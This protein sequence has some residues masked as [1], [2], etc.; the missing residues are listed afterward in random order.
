MPV[1]E[2]LETELCTENIEINWLVEN[3]DEIP[4]IQYDKTK[5][6]PAG[7]QKDFV[8]ESN[9]NPNLEIEIRELE[10]LIQGN[11]ILKDFAQSKILEL[12]E[13]QKNQSNTKAYNHSYHYAPYDF[14]DSQEELDVYKSL[15]Q[16]QDLNEQNIECYYSGDRFLSALK[17]NT[18]Q[19]KGKIGH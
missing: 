17:I 19:K 13:L 18:Y 12:L 10:K 5:W 6:N 14:K 16:D 1:Q 9:S 2:E 11:S 8:G 4:L 3:F 7:W 15:I